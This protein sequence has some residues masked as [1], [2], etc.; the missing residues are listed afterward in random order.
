[1]KDQFTK[2]VQS[3]GMTKPLLER[4]ESVLSFYEIVLTSPI[5]DLFVSEYVNEEK[6]RV[7]ESL[8]LFSDQAIM[9]A[10][11]FV[12]DDVYDW[13]PLPESIMYWEIKRK[14]FDLKTAT[15]KSRLFLTVRLHGSGLGTMRAELKASA[16]NCDQL[17]SIF[18]LTSCPELESVR[19]K[20]FLCCARLR[21]CQSFTNDQQN[22]LQHLF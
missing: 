12:S 22:A 21:N 19:L 2:Y 16:A 1:M 15:E 5:K 4:A 13:A 17:F 11:Q 6:T 14:D 9:E 3:L 10:K 7:Y 18:Q 20:S 8:Y